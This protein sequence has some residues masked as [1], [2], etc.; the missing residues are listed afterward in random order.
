MSRNEAAHILEKKICQVR[1]PAPCQYAHKLALLVGDALH[2]V[3][4]NVLCSG[5][6]SGI[7]LFGT[8]NHDMLE[9]QTF[10]NCTNIIF[11]TVLLFCHM[12]INIRILLFFFSISRCQA[13]LVRWMISYISCE[14]LSA[15]FSKSL[16]ICTHLAYSDSDTSWTFLAAQALV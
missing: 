3:P 2:K 11:A 7:S 16:S 8:W 4:F 13:Q 10:H 1:V 6:T 14:F 15:T 5:I 9:M 12:C